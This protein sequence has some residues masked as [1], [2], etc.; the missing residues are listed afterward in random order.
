MGKTQLDYVYEFEKKKPTAVWFVQPT[1]GGVVKEITW[2]EALDEARRMATH[3]ASLG[4]PPKSQIALFS[5]NTAW[6]MIADLA[7]WMAGHVS[8]PLY[9]TL[10]AATIRQILEHSEAKL[11]LI[12]KLDGF[13]EME[14][15]I[16]PSL[17][18]IAMP[19]APK[20]DAPSWEEIV[21]KTT[22]T[23]GS[24]TRDSSDLATIIYTS[25]TT[26]TPKGVMHSF[27]TMCA[28]ARVHS[29]LEMNEDDR[30]LSYLPLAH[31]FE[32]TV[33]ETSTFV[34]G[35]KVYFAES[36]DTFVKDIQ[37]A[38]PTLFASVPRL[39]LKFYQGVTAKMP[40]KRLRTLLKIPIIKGIIG[41]KI[42]TGLGLAN[43]RY[44]ITG[45]APIPPEL[46]AWYRSIGLELLEGYGMSENF[47]YSHV[48]RPGQLKVGTV[49]V[50]NPDVETKISPEG[51]VLVKGPCT[52]LGYFKAPE[53]TA[54]VIDAEGF[55]HTGDRGSIDSEGFL[56]ITGRVKELF[57]TSKGKYV[58]PAPIEN[59]L[60]A[61]GTI[62][63]CCVQGLA[64]PQPYAVI[65]LAEQHRK[66]VATPEGKAQIEAEL[67]SH[68]GRLNG[69][70]DQHEQLELL[71]V[72]GAPWTIENGMLT[73]TLKVK[74]ALI[75][76]KY[77][78]LAE[79][80][81]AERK[82]VVWL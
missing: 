7:I 49:G 14:P 65:V 42:R 8:V 36:L 81:Y 63:L 67:Q 50:N 39:W 52:M 82:T 59:R 19:L 46:L 24:P 31:A 20:M 28:S 70:L 17:P 60:L 27:D 26:G 34:Q 80:W 75:E 4:F 38:Q 68:L 55:V 21:A 64:L 73:P 1:G 11:I 71:A 62:E 13:A 22:P 57:K 18:R 16:P 3:L 6:W 2:A 35:F 72:E 25:G 78:K 12:G 51:E 40:E 53:L 56:K 74:R 33:V 30:M 37:R 32:R 9:P 76:E 45:S 79:G 23:I 44:G 54:E 10:T 69:E 77:S 61:G 66:V 15:G 43:V 29:V 58:A 47:S 41:K 48:N 5:K